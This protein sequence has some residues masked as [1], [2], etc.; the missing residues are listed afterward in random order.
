[1]EKLK[2]VLATSDAALVRKRYQDRI[3]R[4]GVTVASLN[5]GTPEKQ[6]ILH[7]LHS[8][9]LP[10]DNPEVLDI[11][12]GLAHFFEFMLEQELP[13]SY[14]GYDIVP[15]Y[16]EACRKRHPGAR[17][18]VRNIFEEGID[19]YYDTIIMSQVLNN[20]YQDSDNIAV[21]RSALA[22]AFEHA[23]VSVSIDMLSTYVDYEEPHLFYYSPVAIFQF[24]KTL[25][26]H[27][28]LRHDCH[29]FEFCIQLFHEDPPGFTP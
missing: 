19:G 7:S 8:A 2:T 24:A 29:P 17:F 23:R 18:S 28:A 20:R 14:C 3:A 16:V 1:M 4:H 6:R 25:T 26:R 9:A 5:A 13:R 10:A 11:G 15:E 12:C 22:M 27:V 21:M